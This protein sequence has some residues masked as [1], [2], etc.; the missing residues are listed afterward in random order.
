MTS[1]NIPKL[2][3]NPQ[4]KGNNFDLILKKYN[5]LRISALNPL[6]APTPIISINGV[7]ISTEGNIMILSG[8]SKSGKSALCNV[9]LAGAICPIGQQYDGFQGIDIEP[10]YQSKAVLH[11]DTEQST[12]QHYKSF[13]NSIL[14]RVALSIEPTLYYT[15]NIR[16]IDIS[17]YRS[18][19]RE[20]FESVYKK[21]NGIHLAVI[22]GAADFIKSVND[23]E[24]SN[25]IIKFF[26]QLAIEFKPP[27]IL[28]I[29]FNP[30]SEKQRG[31][32][33]SQLQRKAESVIAIKK[34]EGISYIEPQLLR[35]GSN[36]NIPHIQF[37]YDETKGYHISCGVFNKTSKEDEEKKQLEILAKTVFSDIPMS[38]TDA[39]NKLTEITKSS[40]RT[41]STRLK[42]MVELELVS[43]SKGKLYSINTN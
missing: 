43:K 11:F 38:F 13:K 19:C 25:A 17:K 18:M 4:V 27:I 34:N 15:Y 8:D 20:I 10:N 3:L 21:H 24:E 14:N 16:E 42:K 5:R 22:D 40:N 39:I 9:I 31:H 1:K 23:E 7:P 30:K 12:H 36:A 32:L 26:E 6:K 28:I 29:H 2:S 37:S 41:M 35:N 33:G